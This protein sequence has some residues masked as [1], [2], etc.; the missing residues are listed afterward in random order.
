MI[1]P[2]TLDITIL[3][4]STFRAVFRALER[5]RLITGFAVNN[6][7]PVFTVADHDYIAG[8][9]VVFVPSGTN[10]AEYPNEGILS[11]PDVPSGLDLNRV[12][13]VSATGLTADTFT[14]AE[15][16]GGTPIQVANTVLSQGIV[17]AQPPDLTG[18]TLDAD[19]KGLIDEQE[20]AT[21]VCALVTPA[22][23]L[24]SVSMLPSVSLG[25]EAGRYGWDLSLTS[26]AGER[27]YWLTGTATV[28]RTFS[29]NI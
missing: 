3:Q 14:V 10:S 2:A 21:F 27:Y 9:K 16:N 26:G 6:G 5:Q 17:V 13:F 28:Q 24:V 12:Y 23:G 11:E 7:N 18:F 15:T 25:I 4:N 1:Y 22:D 20:V 19:L 8:Q 29:R